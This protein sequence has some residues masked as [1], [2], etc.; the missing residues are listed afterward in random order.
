L[1]GCARLDDTSSGGDLA[2]ACLADVV[3]LR[4]TDQAIE[5]ARTDIA[6]LADPL[7]ECLEHL[8]GDGAGGL[9]TSE[10]D[11]VA[12][13]VGLDAK[14]VFDQGQ[15]SIVFAEQ[16]RQMQIVFKGDDD[17]LLGLS[18]SHAPGT[19]STNAVQ[20]LISKPNRPSDA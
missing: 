4:V 1:R 15:M 16:T 14:A 18:S 3:H 5:I 8:A 6:A 17:T 7:V 10:D 2:L 11:D 20:T 13:G 9:G 12:V 19:A